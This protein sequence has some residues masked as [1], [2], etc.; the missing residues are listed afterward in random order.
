MPNPTTPAPDSTAYRVLP[1]ASITVGP[2]YRTAMGDLDALAASILDVGLLNPVTVNADGLLLAGER[3]LRALRDMLGWTYIPCH[4]VDADA[5]Q[6]EHEENEQRAPLMLAERV[7]IGKAMEARIGERRGRPPVAPEK[8]PTSAQYAGQKTRDIAARAAGFGGHETYRQATSVVDR[9]VPELAL[10]VDE[11]RLTVSAAAKV[12]A[13]PEEKQR[14]ALA[15]PTAHVANNSGDNEWYTPAEY[16]AAAHAVM[17]GI[18]LDPASTEEANGTVGAR[19][20]FTAEQD[21][22]A[23]RWC[24]ETGAPAALYMNPPYATGLV[25]RFAAKLIEERDAGHVRAAVVL[26]NNSTETRWFQA[27][28]AGASA[29]CL[30]KGRVKFWHPRKEAVPLQGQAILYLGPDPDAFCRAFR[31]LGVCFRVVC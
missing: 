8:V 31:D 19:R 2:R 16:I 25:D 5:L 10:A 4:V 3:R 18:D 9:G 15:A 29:L 30:P 23:Q 28:A 13:L 21:G 24:T 6:V 26:T 20:F 7:G 17:G 14:A 11:G 12:A 1:A 27:M 22:L